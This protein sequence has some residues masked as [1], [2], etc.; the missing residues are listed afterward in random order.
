MLARI[1][2]PPHGGALFDYVNWARE[3]QGVTRAWADQELGPGTITVRFMMD[4]TYQDG[5]PNA[6]DVDTVK[7]Y[8][9]ERRPVT[10]EVFVV[11]PTA[12]PIDFEIVLLNEDGDPISDP[13]IQAAVEAEIKDLFK[14]ESEPGG[15]IYLS[16]IRE[17]ISIAQGEFAH[18]LIAPTGNV[19]AGTGEIPVVGTLTWS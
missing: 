3:V 17:A 12:T 1:Q 19:V 10:A 15:T 8:I 9:D 16:R 18:N 7:A 13:T 5:I 4:D 2:Q 14:R 11:A 6:G